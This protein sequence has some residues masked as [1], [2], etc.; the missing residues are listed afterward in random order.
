VTKPDPAAE[1]DAKFADIE[2]A[3]MTHVAVRARDLDASVDFYRRYARLHVVHEREDG[4]IRVAWLS[5]TP[6]DPDFVIVVLE[7][8]HERMIEPCA[9]DHFGFAVRSRAEVDAIAELARSEGK[10][11]WG[12]KDAGRVVGYIA[13]VRDPSGNTCEFSYGQ[14]IDPR[15]LDA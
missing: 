15:K 2:P 7:M 3:V 6:D 12:P 13:M 14:S 10:L 1:S 11:K 5:H 8:V 9:T 4:G